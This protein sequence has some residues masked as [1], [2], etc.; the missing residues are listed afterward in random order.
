MVKKD[1]N[2]ID[3]EQARKKKLEEQEIEELA[4]DPDFIKFVQWKDKY[5]VAEF[6]IGPDGIILDEEKDSEDE[7]A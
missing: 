6:S 2:V 4:K 5:V 3:F 7:N 1:E